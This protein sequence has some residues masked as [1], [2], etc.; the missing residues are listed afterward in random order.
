MP[1]GRNGCRTRKPA[2]DAAATGLDDRER[3]IIAAHFGLDE[4]MP[5]TYQEVGDRLG[6]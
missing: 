1:L 4:E 5:A 2:I 6:L 3:S